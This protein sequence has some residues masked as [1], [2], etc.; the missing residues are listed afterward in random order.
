M[1]KQAQ[2]AEELA[3]CQTISGGRAGCKPSILD[4]ALVLLYI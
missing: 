1:R 3:Q 4:Q 2:G